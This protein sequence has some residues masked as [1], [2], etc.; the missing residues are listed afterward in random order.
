MESKKAL[1]AVFEVEAADLEPAPEVLREQRISEAA[2]R[3]ILAGGLIGLVLG[4][5]GGVF[6]VTRVFSGSTAWGMAAA[7]VGIVGVF[8]GIAFGIKAHR[9]IHRAADSRHTEK[10]GE[11]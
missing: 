10:R 8:V 5:A 6:G 1:A 3:S 9:E 7:L 11:G 4:L 2:R